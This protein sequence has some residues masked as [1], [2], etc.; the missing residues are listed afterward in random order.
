M[1]LFVKENNLTDV[2]SDCQVY[3]FVKITNFMGYD[4]DCNLFMKQTIQLKA[5][6]KQECH[7]ICAVNN[8][9]CSLM[10]DPTFDSC[11]ASI[12]DNLFAS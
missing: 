12:T 6:F 3:I 8:L 7:L 9:P 10:Y 1:G 5:C 2:G 11:G 4:V